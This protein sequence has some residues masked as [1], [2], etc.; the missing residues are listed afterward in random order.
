[1]AGFQLGITSGGMELLTRG[2]AGSEVRFT[3]ILMG[4]GSYSGSISEAASV[5]SPKVALP[6]SRLTRKNSQVTVKGVLQFGAVE[7]GFT[8]REVGLMALDP[9][10]GKE[11]LY[12]YGTG[13][14]DY[15][16]GAS[17]ATRDERA[18][19]LTVLVSAAENITADL[20]SS[21]VYV[22]ADMLE[23][24]IGRAVV[25]LTHEKSGTVHALTGL[26]GRR[27]LVCCCFA[28]AADY[29]AGDTFTV[30]GE[31]CTVLLQ[32]GSE[33]AGGLFVAGAAVSV[34]VDTDGG[35]INFKAGGGSKLPAYK[36]VTGTLTG[37]ANGQTVTVDG[38]IHSAVAFM[39]AGSQTYISAV[40][41]SKTTLQS[42]H[43]AGN[44]QSG[45]VSLPAANTFR[46]ANADSTQITYWIFYS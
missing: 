43:N 26:L 5:L 16:P 31:T 28:A 8:W 13:G 7:E 22:D 37:G 3:S 10:T 38:T 14:S 11:V 35:T 45:T 17:E 19:Q 21:A 12:A 32:D 18:V 30:D 24:A 6:I 23:E 41:P 27:G 2:L 40:C 44:H 4:D 1:M 42:F 20:D 39:V 46:Y 33:A 25:P 36:M 15:I 34:L 9:D 29:T